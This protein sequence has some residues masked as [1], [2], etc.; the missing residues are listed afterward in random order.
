VRTILSL[1]EA[2]M[3]DEMILTL[4]AI[5]LGWLLSYEIRED[6]RGRLL[7]KPF[8]SA[9]F[10]LVALAGP[11][12]E[13]G[14]FG[15]V[16]AGLVFCMAGD[17]FLI[18]SASPRLFLAGLVSFLMGHILYA[19][20]FFL[21][22]RPGMLTGIAGAGV[23]VASGAIFAWLRPHLGRML[24][25][26]AAYVAVISVMVIGASS[27]MEERTADLSGRTLVFAGAVLFY[28]SDVFVARQQFVTGHYVN[29]L[30]GLPLYYVAQ[31][32]IAFSIRYF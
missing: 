22:S 28:V 21:A 6:T 12:T 31:F 5:L 30:I 4:A 7:T 9:L 15:W 25:P 14:Y 8:L 18:F 10:V 23:L 29:R 13:T 26:V 11:R 17:V 20:A 3:T 24:I 19:A 16:L 32:M 1:T 2:G 27:V